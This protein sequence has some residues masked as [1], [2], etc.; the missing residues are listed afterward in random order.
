MTALAK[1]IPVQIP[2][3]ATGLSALVPLGKGVPVG[4]L[5]PAGWLAGNLTFR[6]MVDDVIANASDIYDASGNELTI[7]VG[8]ASR[9]IAIDP[10]YFV[11]FSSILIRSGTTGTP[12]N[13]TGAP[14]L[15]LVTKEY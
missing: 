1:Y 10:T 5:I 12:V 4:I 15:T 2:A 8:G 3:G 7:T 14:T 9:Y 6:A 13:Q 11:G